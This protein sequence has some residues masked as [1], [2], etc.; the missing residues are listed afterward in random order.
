MAILKVLFWWLLS[1]V[2]YAAAFYFLFP[3][4]IAFI[5]CVV[6]GMITGHFLALKY[7]YDWSK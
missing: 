6:A 5:L 7:L 1:S 3:R 4:S 2:V